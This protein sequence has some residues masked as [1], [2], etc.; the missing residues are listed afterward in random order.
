MPPC[1]FIYHCTCMHKPSPTENNS[2]KGD[3]NLTSLFMKIILCPLIVALSAYV[4]P[5]VNFSHMLQPILIGL[6]LAVVGTF[7]EY[8]FLKKGSVWLSTFL[9]FV[10]SVII[11]YGLSLFMDGAIVT[12]VGALI[13]SFVLA[14]T[15]YFTHSYLVNT[16]KTR[17]SPA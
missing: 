7:M 14:V 9:D 3:G 10:A 16:N 4:L 17:K 1:F 12:F 11:I 6:V 15:E 2:K 13:V 8:L 5:N